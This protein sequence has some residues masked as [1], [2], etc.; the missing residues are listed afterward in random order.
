MGFG[1]SDLDAGTGTPCS[2]KAEILKQI[3][4]TTKARTLGFS[5]GIMQLLHIK[6]HSVFWHTG[7]TLPVELIEVNI[8]YQ[9]AKKK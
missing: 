4:A 3:T 2:A 5:L 8:M 6:K 9:P 1:L 7:I